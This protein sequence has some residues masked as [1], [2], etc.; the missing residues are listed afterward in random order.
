MAIAKL[1]LNLLSEI[2]VTQKA[3]K[4]YRELKEKQ[5]KRM[6]EAAARRSVTTLRKIFLKLNAACSFTVILRTAYA[7]SAM[8]SRGEHLGTIGPP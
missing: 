7:Q 4:H 3:I 1:Q 6:A 8:G 2:A 5:E